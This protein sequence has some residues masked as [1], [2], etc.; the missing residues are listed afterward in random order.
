MVCE[1]GK[2][3]KCIFWG[4]GGFDFSDTL[5]PVRAL[6]KLFF[7][8]FFLFIELVPRMTPLEIVLKKAPPSSS[9]HSFIIYLW[10]VESDLKQIFINFVFNFK[11]SCSSLE[12]NSLSYMSRSYI[13]FSIGLK[14]N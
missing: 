10:S 3:R 5:R 2:A 6:K 13:T 1:L 9:Y 14:I 11:V 7:N 8:S 12:L 4:G